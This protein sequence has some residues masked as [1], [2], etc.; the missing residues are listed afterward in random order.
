MGDRL[1]TQKNPQK[2]DNGRILFLYVEKKRSKKFVTVYVENLHKNFYFTH[3]LRI[4]FDTNSTQIRHKFDTTNSTQ[5][6]CRIRHEF[7]PIYVSNSTV[8]LE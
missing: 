3:N 2:F 1:G 7:D 6:T 4:K 8:E 5:S